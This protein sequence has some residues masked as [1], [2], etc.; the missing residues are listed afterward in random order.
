MRDAEKKKKQLR[1]GYVHERRHAIGPSP[2]PAVSSGVSVG[3]TWEV[4]SERT[5]A[6]N[7]YRARHPQWLPP[8]TRREMLYR[9]GYTEKEVEA[10]RDVIVRAQR[11]RIRS[12]PP[13]SLVEQA[14]WF[15]ARGVRRSFRR[16]F[17]K[18]PSTDSLRP[19]DLLDDDD[20]PTVRL[21]RDSDS[22]DKLPPASILRST[23]VPLSSDDDDV[24]EKLPPASVLRSRSVPYGSDVDDD[25]DTT[26]VTTSQRAVRLAT[27]QQSTVNL[28]G[29]C[30]S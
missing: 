27:S 4:V 25:D 10:V 6:V 30:A 12:L 17:R 11:D 29:I 5:V 9:A 8:V 26:V 16:A 14:P 19:D 7:E 21:E 13:L 15:L 28:V 22:D 3:L 20:A 1:F 24:V 2:N 23:S 18:S